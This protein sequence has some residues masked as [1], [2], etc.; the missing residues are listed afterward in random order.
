[1]VKILGQRFALTDPGFNGA[2]WAAA[3]LKSS[4]LSTDADEVFD[5]ISRS[6]QAAVEHVNNFLKRA[7]LSASFQ[8]S[9]TVLTNC[10]LVSSLYAGGTTC[11]NN[12]VITSPIN[13]KNVFFF[14]LFTW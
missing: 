4:Q 1:L 14:S 9:S 11:E 13:K 8:S 7:L 10:Y 6:E 2:D 5:D 12:K 3:S